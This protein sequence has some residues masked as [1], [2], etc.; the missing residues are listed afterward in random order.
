MA[1][2]SSLFNDFE[3]LINAPVYARPGATRG[4]PKDALPADGMDPKVASSLISDELLLDGNA[5]QNLATFVTTFMEPEATALFAQSA[6]KNMID[7]DEYPQTAAIEGRCVRILSSLWNSPD[8]ENATGTSTTGSSEAV[9]LGG[10]ALKWKWRQRR[11]AAAL[12]TDRPNLVMGSNVQVVWEKFCRYWDVEPRYAP[13]EAGRLQ[14]NAEEALKL[15]DQN[16]IGVVAILGSTFDGSYEPVKEI[17]EALDQLQASGGPDVPIHVDAASGG[18]I[19]PFLDPQLEWDFRV[20]RVRSINASGHKYGLVY[21]GVGWVIWRTPADLPDDL[22][23]HVNYLGG[24]MPTFALNFSRPGAQVI[25]QYYNFIRLGFEGYRA[26]QQACRDTAMFLAEQIARIGPFQLLSDG[27][28]L[29]VFFFRLKPEVVRYTVFDLSAK[30]RERGWQVPAYS[31]PDH[32][33]DVSGLRVV[34]RNGFGRD[35]AELFLQ[36]LI[37]ATT[38]LESLA[39]KLPHDPGHTENFRH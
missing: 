2:H 27:S 36:D 38:F 26:I 6:D 1:L 10:L 39:A 35:L 9:M 19:A 8:H 7:K 37:G 20:P 11:A 16:S 30:L 31:L 3:R 23:F 25:A 21:P 22:V 34:V 13:I 5:R 28:E 14:L 32:L 4:I 15:V 29:P 17:S 33:T 18:F 24:D 12:P